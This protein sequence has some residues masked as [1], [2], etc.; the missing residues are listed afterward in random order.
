MRG[1]VELKAFSSL[2]SLMQVRLWVV[3]HVDDS[4]SCPHSLFIP[5]LDQDFM[6]LKND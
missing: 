5:F 3:G 4:D 2:S 6:V 1:V